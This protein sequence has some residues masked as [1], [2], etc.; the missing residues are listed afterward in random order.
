MSVSVVLVFP[1]EIHFCTGPKN[2][3]IMLATQMPQRDEKYMIDQ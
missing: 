1:R 2:K 3:A